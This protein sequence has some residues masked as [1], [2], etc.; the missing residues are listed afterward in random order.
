M[1]LPELSAGMYDALPP[2][3]V[4][5]LFVHAVARA[6]CRHIFSDLQCVMCVC[7]NVFCIQHVTMSVFVSLTQHPLFSSK[8][9]ACYCQSFL[10]AC[11]MRCHQVESVFFSACYCQS[12]LQACII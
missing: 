5:T 3:G 9:G 8:R 12:F 1:L 6:V 2:S 11:M 4:S 10:Q 7:S